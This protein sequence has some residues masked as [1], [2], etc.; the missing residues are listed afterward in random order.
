MRT[1]ERKNFFRSLMAE[2]LPGWIKQKRQEPRFRPRAD[3]ARS[4]GTVQ[5]DRRSSTEEKQAAERRL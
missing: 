1:R 2:L 4:S 5:K 3:P